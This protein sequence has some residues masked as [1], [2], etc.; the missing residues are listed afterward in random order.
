MPSCKYCY[1]QELVWRKDDKGYF[2]TDHRGVWH[3]CL[4]GDP[5]K[6]DMDAHRRYIPESMGAEILHKILRDV[7]ASCRSR[8]SSKQ[9]RVWARGRAEAIR[10]RLR[11]L[12]KG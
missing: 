5:T 7:E 2:L 3:T 4:D 12:N 11:L 6:Q 9:D 10:D 1:E 8:D